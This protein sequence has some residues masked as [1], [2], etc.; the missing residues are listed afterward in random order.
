LDKLTYNRFKIN[1]VDIG[2]AYQ[3]L[4][5]ERLWSRPTSL[6]LGP[7]GP[8]LWPFGPSFGGASFGVF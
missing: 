2:N 4:E 3:A 6:G 5:G 1:G 7:A 8:L